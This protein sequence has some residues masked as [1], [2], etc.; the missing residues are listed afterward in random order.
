MSSGG[1]EFL[2]QHNIVDE[3]TQTKIMDAITLC[4]KGTEL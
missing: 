3:L 1:L 2:M 4:R